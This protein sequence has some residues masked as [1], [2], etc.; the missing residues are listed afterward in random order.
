[1]TV[2]FFLAALCTSNSIGAD[3][4]GADL[5][6]LWH[7]MP[8]VGSGYAEFYAF[9]VDGSFVWRENGMDGEARLRERR[10]SW[11]MEGDSL[12]LLV[13]TDLVWE[14]GSLVPAT[15]SVGTD[16]ELIG[17]TPMYYD[18]F[19]PEEVRLQVGRPSLERAADNPDLPVDM[20]RMFIGGDPFWRLCGDPSVVR[21]ILIRG[22]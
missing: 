5:E 7:A 12:V 3:L 18:Y 17:F 13:S 2:L 9:F 11:C 6:G 4:T 20:W 1:M 21:E 14:G 22:Y 8:F 19:I 10:G 15:G 16:S